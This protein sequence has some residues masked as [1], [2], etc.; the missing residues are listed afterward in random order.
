MLRDYSPE[1]ASH[2]NPNEARFTRANVYLYEQRTRK[3]ERRKKEETINVS[4]T[5]NDRI[6]LSIVSSKSSNSDRR[7]SV[8]SGS[9]AALISSPSLIGAGFLE[10]SSKRGNWWRIARY[11]EIC[12]TKKKKKKKE[13][14]KRLN[15]TVGANLRQ[16]E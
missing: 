16:S 14:H 15:Q 12:S 4:R 11:A 7:V 13:K 2:E 3:G 1:Q 8:L 5:T 9:F 6:L 10:L